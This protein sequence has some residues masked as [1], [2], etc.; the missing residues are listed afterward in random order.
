MNRSFS[1]YLDLVRF[2]A[3]V[4]VYMYHSNQRFLSEAIL[5]MSS[6]GHSSVIVFFVLSGFVI[7]YVTDTK[8]NRFSS[9]AASRTSR[10]FSVTVPAIALTLLLDTI[11]R[12]LYPAIY[13]GYPYDQFILRTLGSLLLGNEIWFVSITSFSNVPYWSICYEWW[14][15]VAFAFIVFLPRYWGLLMAA[16]LMLTLGPK[17][18]LLAPIWGLGVLL[19]RSRTMLEISLG[20][21]WTLAI[22]SVA[23]ILV[24]HYLDLSDIATEWLKSKIG[25]DLHKNLTFSK[26]FIADYLLG[27]LVFGNFLAMRR[28]LQEHSFGLSLIEKPV[29]FVAGLTFTLYLLH[30][31]LFLFWGAVVQGN[32]KDSGYWWSVTGLMFLSVILVGY[33]T[34]NK[35]HI[36]KRWLETQLLRIPKL[37][38]T[39]P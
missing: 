29:R 36:L 7:A 4:L 13:S 33:F 39:A 16:I 24:F 8:E 32:P 30:Q 27:L 26:F 21:A 23:G 12:S 25:E 10:V 14:Y 15:Y 22:L 38:T 6:Y 17:V 2:L 20:M 35:R 18:L 11:G 31:P 9:Y 28:I 34:E 19:Y 3:A 5:P 1:V 37:R